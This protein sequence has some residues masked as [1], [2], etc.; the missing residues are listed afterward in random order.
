MAYIGMLKLQLQK[1]EVFLDMYGKISSFNRGSVA[2][3][4]GQPVHLRMRTAY[5]LVKVRV[6]LSFPPPIKNYKMYNP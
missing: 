5:D 4:T 6:P 2:W 1:L 3:C